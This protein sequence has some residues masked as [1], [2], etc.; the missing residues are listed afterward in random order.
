MTI[1]AAADIQVPNTLTIA[2]SHAV[3]ARRGAYPVRVNRRNN[4]GPK[5]STA[6]L[7]SSRQTAILISCGP[8]LP[9]DATRPAAAP[10]LRR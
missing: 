4:R 8:V 3:I 2:A 1:S 5:I 10:I 7:Y 6:T 9:V